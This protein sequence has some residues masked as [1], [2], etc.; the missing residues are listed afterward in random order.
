[1]RRLN[2]RSIAVA[3]YAVFRFTAWADMS[4]TTDLR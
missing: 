2:N 3:E 1:M 4:G